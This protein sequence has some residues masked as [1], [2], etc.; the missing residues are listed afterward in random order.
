MLQVGGGLDL[1]EESLRADDRCQLGL[2]DL[3]SDVAV[4]LQVLA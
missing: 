4:V 3:E 2:E 1:G